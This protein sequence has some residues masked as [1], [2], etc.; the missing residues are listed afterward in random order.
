MN[1][2]NKY[3]N[4]SKN[5]NLPEEKEIIIAQLMDIISDINTGATINKFNLLKD[6]KHYTLEADI[7][8]KPLSEFHYTQEAMNNILTYPPKRKEKKQE[9]DYVDCSQC[10]YHNYD[11]NINDGYG[12]DEYEICEKG[13][14][15]YPK[16]CEYFDEL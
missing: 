9:K 8:P 6:L 10:S 13:H 1:M 5:N 7:T 2:K 11:W 12:G 16:E 15:L 4:I 14:E 3:E